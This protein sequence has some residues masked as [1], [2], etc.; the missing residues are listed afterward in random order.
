M[1]LGACRRPVCPPWEGGDQ[2]GAASAVTRNAKGQGELPGGLVP[3]LGAIP[4]GMRK[5]VPSTG[6]PRHIS[7]CVDALPAVVAR[8]TET[9]DTRQAMPLSLA[10]NGV[11]SAGRPLK[12]Y[13]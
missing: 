13:S 1:Q 5:K 6:Q 8:S 7:R 4:A 2:A 12:P 10:G 3:F 11:R 9:L